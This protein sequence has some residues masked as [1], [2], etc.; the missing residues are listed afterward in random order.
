MLTVLG[1]KSMAS[2][3]LDEEEAGLRQFAATIVQAWPVTPHPMNGLD[4]QAVIR[5]LQT[6]KLI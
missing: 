6:L 3:V 4:R 5:N 1:F 2:Q